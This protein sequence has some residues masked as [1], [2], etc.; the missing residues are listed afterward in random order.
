MPNPGGGSSTNA[1]PA[2]GRVAAA[3]FDGGR[4]IPKINISGADVQQIRQL[5]DKSIQ[6]LNAAIGRGDQESIR[7]HTRNVI[8]AQN[9]IQKKSAAA[10]T[11]P[12]ASFANARAAT[13]AAQLGGPGFL[14]KLAVM[15]KAALGKVAARVARFAG[16][17]GSLGARFSNAA[18]A[19]RGAVNRRLARGAVNARRYA[20]GRLD[21][22]SKVAADKGRSL[23]ERRS[24]AR[25]FDREIQGFSKQYGKAPKS[26]VARGYDAAAVHKEL[27]I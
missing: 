20:E 13:P 14:R 3:Q 6:S 25:S 7:R 2:A 26:R 4:N 5:R 17:A 24:A 12:A 16:N 11:Q 18:T 9:E 8:L 15:G 23:P 27:G 1:A 19:V 21:S 10:K 22:L